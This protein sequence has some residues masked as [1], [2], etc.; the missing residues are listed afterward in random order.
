MK[1]YVKLLKQK[2]I[3]LQELSNDLVS[4]IKPCIQEKNVNKWHS[5]LDFHGIL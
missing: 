1:S 3:Q 4:F 5:F 2:T